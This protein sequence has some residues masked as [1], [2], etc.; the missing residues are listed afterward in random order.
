[1]GVSVRCHFLF[2][3]L[4]HVF[5]CGL[6]LGVSVCVEISGG[7][8]QSPWSEMYTPRQKPTPSLASQA[9]SGRGRLKV[10]CMCCNYNIQKIIGV[11]IVVDMLC[12]WQNL[13]GKDWDVY[14]NVISPTTR[15]TDPISIWWSHITLLLTS[16]SHSSAMWS[17]YLVIFIL[18]PP[19][20][21]ILILLKLFW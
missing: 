17:Q 21:Q 18:I 14:E 9:S 8:C 13:K 3:C 16:Q 1:M 6:C 4:V 12:W 20:S 10:I 7:F 2:G 5:S 15:Q 19:Q 11:Q